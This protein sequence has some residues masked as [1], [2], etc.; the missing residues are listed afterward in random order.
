MLIIEIIELWYFLSL[1]CFFSIRCFNFFV[2]MNCYHMWIQWYWIHK[3]VHTNSTQYV[4]RINVTYPSI[5]IIHFCLSVVTLINVCAFYIVDF[6]VMV[7][8]NGFGSEVFA[9]YNTLDFSYEKQYHQFFVFA[10]NLFL[11]LFSFFL[12]LILLNSWFFLT[13]LVFTLLN[14]VLWW[15]FWVHGFLLLFFTEPNI[16]VSSFI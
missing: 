12:S 9:T 2:V 10:N 5:I 11:S 6:F 7:E 3:Y 4:L 15:F 1:V 13:L 16:K 14:T 8:K